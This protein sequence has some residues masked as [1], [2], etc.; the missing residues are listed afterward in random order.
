M[1]VTGLEPIIL[2]AVT[3]TGAIGES[4]FEYKS[5]KQD[6][7]NQLQSAKNAEQNAAYERQEGIDDA[8]QRRLK[9]IQNMGEQKV[10]I[11]SGNIMTSSISALDIEE[12]EKLSGEFDALKIID[13]AKRKS[14]A[15]LE[16]ANKYYLGAYKTK[17]NLKHKILKK[18]MKISMKTASNALY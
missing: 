12:D 16:T 6:I 18:G 15:Y 14:D 5:A 2:A 10:Q 4:I 13:N 11:A 9:A 3:T 7:K 17:M 8:R 1:C